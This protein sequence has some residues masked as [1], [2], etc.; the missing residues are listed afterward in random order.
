MSLATAISEFLVAQGV[1]HVFTVTGG[2]AQFF[3]QAFG[4]HPKLT[5]VY[6]Q[7]EAGAAY[8]AIA[9]TRQ[10]GRPSVVCT[11][12]GCAATNAVTGVL[13]AFQDSVPVF[14]I[15]GQVNVSEIKPGRRHYMGAWSPITEIVKSITKFASE[16]HSLDDAFIAVP[17]A[18]N[19]CVSGRPGPVWLSVPLDVQRATTDDTIPL[20][21][22]TPTP[23]TALLPRDELQRAVADALRLAKRPV[24]MIGGGAR[25]TGIRALVDRLGVPCIFTFMSLDIIPSDSPVYGG[26]VGVVGDRS[27]NLCMQNADVIVSLGCRWSGSVIGYNTATFCREGRIVAVDVHGRAGRPARARRQAPGRRSRSFGHAGCS[28]GLPGSAV[29]AAHARVEGQVVP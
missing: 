25:H 22:A 15:S 17:H 12:A 10:S 3:N 23:Q 5:C 14:F 4:A 8:A 20:T 24:I 1:T 26:R 11:T 13:D 7:S 28:D 18:W 19:A 27:G 29:G 2:Y 16:P 6:T 21:P 9:Y